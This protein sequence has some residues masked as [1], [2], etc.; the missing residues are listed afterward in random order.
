MRKVGVLILA[1][2]A[3]LAG[4]VVGGL[5]P[6]SGLTVISQGDGIRGDTQLIV[7]VGISETEQPVT[8]LE[9][10]LAERPGPPPVGGTAKT[11]ERGLAVFWVRPGAYFVYFNSLS[12]PGELRI[13]D[14]QQVEVVERAMNGLTVTLSPK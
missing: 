5:Y 9:V 8:N 10:D 7:A 12:F 4:Y 1:V 13:P 2:A 11:N 6:I 14:P 3:F